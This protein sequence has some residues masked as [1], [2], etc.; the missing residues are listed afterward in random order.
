M[1]HRRIDHQRP[2]RRFL[3]GTVAV[4]IENPAEILP[5][6]RPVVRRDDR[7]VEIQP[8]QRVQKIEHFRRL[9]VE[10][11]CKIFTPFVVKHKL[12]ILIRPE[13][14]PGKV[15]AEGVLRKE[16]FCRIQV[17]HH[18]V[19]PVEHLGFNKGKSS[20]AELHGFAGLDHRK[21]E[22]RSVISPQ[23]LFPERRDKHLLRMN[24]LNRR[25][26]RSG[27]VRLGMV[28]NDVVDLLRI[29]HRTDP[30]QHLT[31]KRRL[32]RV[33]QRHFLVDYQKSVVSGTAPGLIAVKVPHIPVDCADPVDIF[34]DLFR[35]E[36]FLHDSSLKKTVTGTE[37]P[38]PPQRW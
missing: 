3:L 2:R 29:D 13:L 20:L 36:H 18:A 16:Q 21:I 34:G 11:I 17:G 10:N 37:C 35:L 5:P 33:D 19:R 38:P 25:D 4:E 24:R 14:A 28:R 23:C 8:R 22:V 27:M 1:P 12:R 30:G 26:D 9:H 7:N 31:E 32:D 15:H 6:Q